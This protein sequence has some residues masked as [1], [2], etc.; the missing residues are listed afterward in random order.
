MIV[1][2]AKAAEQ[3]GF[4]ELY[5]VDHIAIP[6]DDLEGS[7]G[8]YLD[9]LS[10]LSFLAGLTDQIELCTGVLVMPYRPILP[11]AKVIATA[12]EL[13]GNRL[14]L[15]VGVGWME[16]EFKALGID[17]ARRGR[18]FD[19]GLEFINRAFA[20]DQISHN[21]QE[22]M[23]LPRPVKPPILIGGTPPY[24]FDRAVKFGDGWIP[25]AGKNLEKFRNPISELQE[26]FANA[27][28]GKPQVAIFTR[29]AFEEPAI[30]AG[31]IQEMT[32]IG[33]S[34][35]IHGGVRYRDASEFSDIA[36]AISSAR[37]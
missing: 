2:C 28:R 21:D 8:R 37:G 11:T 29:L 1:D 20:S 22:F 30:M 3:N 16:S 9:P 26:R 27:G 17:R 12:Q 13:S 19:E 24:A 33:V 5:V 4:E 32:D 18:I 10:V 36:E 31:Q 23:F 35:I 25:M 34:S 15:G 6:P 14:K 7:D